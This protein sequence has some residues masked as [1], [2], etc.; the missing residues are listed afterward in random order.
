MVLLIARVCLCQEIFSS[1]SKEL[2]LAT[3]SFIKNIT[4]GRMRKRANSFNTLNANTIVENISPQLAIEFFQCSRS[5]E[6]LELR[7]MRWRLGTA[8]SCEILFDMVKDAEVDPLH[9]ELIFENGQYWIAPVSSSFIWRNGLRVTQKQR[10]DSGD[11]LVFGMEGGPGLLAHWHDPGRPVNVPASALRVRIDKGEAIKSAPRFER[12]FTLGRSQLCD[13]QFDDPSVSLRHAEIRREGGHWFVQDL[14]STNG[15]FLD[16]VRV[17]RAELP[18]QAT[19]ALAKGGPV[20]R[21]EIE[22]RHSTTVVEA[23]PAGASLTQVVQRYF[24]T[25][26]GHAGSQTMLIR[27]A[28]QKVRRKQSHRYWTIIGAVSV[29]CIAVSIALYYQHQRVAKMRGLAEDIFYAM[30]ALD[31]QIAALQTAV[32][33]HPDPQLRQQ[34]KNKKQ[35]QDDLNT[36]YNQFARELGITPDNLSEKEWLVYKIARLFGECDVSMPPDFLRT[37]QAYIGKWQTT[38]RLANAIVRAQANDYSRKIAALMLANDLP[39]QFFYLALQESDF[40]PKRSGPETPKWGIAKGMWQF[41]PSTAIQFGLRTGPLVEVRQ[42]DP[43]DERHDFAKSTAA[44][45]KYLRFLYETE[46]QAS[47]LL[48]IAAYNWGQG[49]VLQRIR[50]LPNNP[51]ARNFWRLLAREKIPAQTYDYVFYIVSAAV[52]GENPRLFGFAFD[53]PLPR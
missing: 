18:A 27:R 24:G 51:R 40:D 42:Y 6:T 29:L 15:I 12:N 28:F 41:I 5:G 11:K 44:A 14:K 13:I 21:L 39:P 46:A 36:S 33:Q 16:G 2:F 37:V 34:V 25:I 35:Q 3:A 30:K 10:L 23:P 31:V 52:I 1:C 9:A 20:I 8:P 43:R 32:A 49:N 47:G 53:N 48:V 4:M 45:A 22:Q 17:E 19:L 38:P 50:N 26:S 7:G